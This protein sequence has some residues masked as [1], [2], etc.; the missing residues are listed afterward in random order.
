MKDIVF[1]KDRI[2]LQKW[3]EKN[4]E[5]LK[6]KFDKYFIGKFNDLYQKT[7]D[8]Y[9]FDSLNRRVLNAMPNQQVVDEILRIE[10]NCNAKHES[11]LRL[12]K[13]EKIRIPSY[14]KLSSHF[15]LNLSMSSLVPETFFEVFLQWEICF[16][17]DLGK[18][19]DGKKFER[20]KALE[21]FRELRAECREFIKTEKKYEKQQEF[22][23]KK[24]KEIFDNIRQGGLF[25]YW[26]EI[27]HW[28]KKISS[29]C[30]YILISSLQP[31]EIKQS[32]FE[33]SKKDLV[34]YKIPVEIEDWDAGEG[35]V[36]GGNIEILEES[37]MKVHEPLIRKSQ[38][39]NDMRPYAE[40]LKRSSVLVHPS[41]GV[42]GLCCDPNDPNAVKDHIALKNRPKDKGFILLSGYIEH[43][44]DLFYGYDFEKI[45]ECFTPGPITY[46]IKDNGNAPKSAVKDGKIAFRFS[47]HPV[48]KSLSKDFGGYFISTSANISGQPPL[49]DIDEVKGYF[50]KEPLIVPGHN[51]DLDKPT[52][53]KDLETGEWIRK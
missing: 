30:G 4:K 7:L 18:I 48:V 42:F 9:Q 38:P 28:L 50:D 2:I 1:S 15:R 29:H 13:N 12:L 33:R 37:K 14:E 22:I 11:L 17:N 20:E 43:F 52:P 39:R 25:V 3:D 34:D 49:K 45:K 8:S 5:E 46:V 16:Y 23:S 36:Y 47:K 27:P 10:R 40:L 31:Y 6:D 41:E 44:F 51:G 53:I 26:S 32:L 21:R 24:S 19:N 35:V